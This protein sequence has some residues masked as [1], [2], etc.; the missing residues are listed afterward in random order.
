MIETVSYRC[1]ACGERVESVVDSS[2]GDCVL[3]ED[4]PVC[5]R[6]L[7]LSLRVEADGTLGGVEVE[8]E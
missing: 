3:T 1:P 6:P 8:R 5:C 4:C 2:A 7:R